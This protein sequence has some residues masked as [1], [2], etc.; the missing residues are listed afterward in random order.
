MGIGIG[1]GY[2]FDGDYMGGNT[3]IALASYSGSYSG[4]EQSAVAEAVSSEQ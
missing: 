4:S 1:D 2:Q 3:E